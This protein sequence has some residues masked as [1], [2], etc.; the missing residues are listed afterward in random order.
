MG[1]LILIITCLILLHNLFFMVGR[2]NSINGINRLINYINQ[3]NNK[4]LEKSI[5]ILIIT[6][7]TIVFVYLTLRIHDLLEIIQIVIHAIFNN[8]ELY[9]SEFSIKNYVYYQSEISRKT[10]FIQFGIIAA[11]ALTIPFLLTIFSNFKKEVFNLYEKFYLIKTDPKYSEYKEKENIDEK[12]LKLD[13]KMTTLNNVKPFILRMG[14]WSIGCYILAIILFFVISNI[15]RSEDNGIK[16]KVIYSNNI[17]AVEKLGIPYD[18]TSKKFYYLCLNFSSTCVQVFTLLGFGLILLCL[19]I[20]FPVFND[21]YEWKKLPNL[22]KPKKFNIL[23]IKNRIIVFLLKNI[24]LNLKSNLF[25]LGPI[26]MSIFLYFFIENFITVLNVEY[27]NILFT[28]ICLILFLISI[29]SSLSYK[30]YH[31]K[32][33]YT[34][35]IITFFICKG[36]FYSNNVFNFEFN[37][38]FIDS[39][40]SYNNEFSSPYFTISLILVCIIIDSYYI[41]KLKL[42]AKNK[43]L[44]KKLKRSVITLLVVN[45]LICIF[46]YSPPYTNFIERLFQLLVYNL[47]FLFSY[48]LSNKYFPTEKI[49]K[50]WDGLHISVK[51]KYTRY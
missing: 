13:I 2:S 6:I 1:I 29:I 25:I 34:I 9:P 23:E 36:I 48:Y 38:K 42:V 10:N 44:H 12:E 22:K 11:F 39:F 16:S 31:S 37:S 20:F 49:K 33:N 17:N 50:R 3:I 26:C 15:N 32:F 4:G 19:L 21:I 30:F 7:T 43:I 51:S 40:F 14:R 46:L 47:I 45:F 28:K 24:D 18:Y 41:I 27:N 8:K 5:Q 35:F